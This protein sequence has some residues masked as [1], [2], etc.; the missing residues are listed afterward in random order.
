[1]L[2]YYKLLEY[3]LE[4]E[5]GHTPIMTCSMHRH[6]TAKFVATPGKNPLEIWTTRVT[7]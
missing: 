2:F 7:M 3:K 6:K 5:H 1:M 4:T